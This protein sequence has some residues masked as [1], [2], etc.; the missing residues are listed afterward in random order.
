MSILSLNQGIEKIEIIENKYVITSVTFR[1][2]K[3]PAFRLEYG[4]IQEVLQAKGVQHP[5][6][7]EVSEAVI[8]I[9][10]SKLP[11]PKEIGNAGSFFKNPEISIKKHEELKKLYENL[12]SYSLP[13][14]NYKLAAGWLIENCGLK[15]HEINGAAV[16]SKQALVLVNKKNCKG[17]DVFNLSNYILEQVAQKFGVKYDDII[18][19]NVSDFDIIITF[20]II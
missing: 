13:N 10:Q 3:T 4:A 16:H 1:L 8:Q 5:S 9:R 6:L 7:R 15:G 2:D 14:G 12:V 11:D 18:N 19:I 20:F 17:I